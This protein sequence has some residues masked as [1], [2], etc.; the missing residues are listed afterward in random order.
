M[1][2]TRCSSLPTPFPRKRAV[3][4]AVQLGKRYPSSSRPESVVVAG[5]G[6]MLVDWPGIKP[7]WPPVSE[8]RASRNLFDQRLDVIAGIRV[9]HFLVRQS[10]PINPDGKSHVPSLIT[11]NLLR[12]HYGAGAITRCL[13]EPLGLPKALEERRHG[14]RFDLR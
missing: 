7:G 4:C 8:P 12:T 9:W 11:G 2:G 5:H 10:L 6:G 13:L 3:A 1:Q 14:F